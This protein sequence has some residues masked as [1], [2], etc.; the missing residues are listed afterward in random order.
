MRNQWWKKMLFSTESKQSKPVTQMPCSFTLGE[1]LR[2]LKDQLQISHLAYRRFLINSHKEAEI[3]YVNGLVDEQKVQ[4]KIL[5]P[6]MYEDHSDSFNPLATLYEYHANDEIVID[7]I[8]DL[9]LKG[10]TILFIDGVNKLFVFST[11]GVPKRSIEEP[12]TESMLKGTHLGFIEVREDNISMVRQYVD[13]QSLK[14]KHYQ[15]GRRKKC[16]VSLMFLDD[17]VHGDVLVE[18]EN[19]LKKVDVDTLLTIGGLEEMIEDNPYSPF[20][21]FLTTERPDT[22]SMHLLQGR[23]AM[24]MDHSSGV[25]VG[26]SNFA[27]FFHTVDDYNLRWSVVSFIRFLRFAAFFLSI[28]LPSIYI[29]VLSFHYEVIPINLY[30]SVAESRERVPLPPIIEAYIMEVTLETLREAGLRLPAPIGQTVGI[31]GGIVI[32][33]A[34]VEAGLVSNIMVIVVALTAISSFILPNQDFAAGA[35]LLR[36]A[37]MLIAAFFGMIGIMFGVMLLIGH[38]IALESLG[39]PYGNPFSPTRF[40]YW[41][42]LILRLPKMGTKFVKHQKK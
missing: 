3:L 37:F 9:L 40:K 15:L 28:L 22:V 10:H 24:F 18:L 35:R 20:P 5:H 4:E 38:L 8:Y 39:T 7:S 29:A 31:V 32:G 23:I 1:N 33:Q 6:L 27:S 25:L 16:T 26:P 11:S 41:G 42:D 13:G 19:R 30:V 36:F 14:I 21:Q 2:F 17:L 12:Q 34:A